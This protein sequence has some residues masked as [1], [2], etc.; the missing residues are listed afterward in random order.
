MKVMLSL[1]D[2]VVECILAYEKSVV[3]SMAAE[4]VNVMEVL[5]RRSWWVCDDAFGTTRRF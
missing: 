3:F 4:I 5:H 1:Q 2:G